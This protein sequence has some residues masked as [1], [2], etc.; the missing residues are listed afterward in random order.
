MS[1]WALSEA[2]GLESGVEVG[3]KAE[4][5]DWGS[6]RAGQGR[7][8]ERRGSIDELA[9]RTALPDDRPEAVGDQRTF[10][11]A[12][13]QPDPRKHWAKSLSAAKK[14]TLPLIKISGIKAKK[15]N[16]INE[17]VRK[18]RKLRQV[19]SQQKPTAKTEISLGDSAGYRERSLE[20]GIDQSH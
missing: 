15:S 19:Q 4:T 9:E 7:G 8:R 20:T 14:P 6:A 17:M 13:S 11:D 10:A 18:V 3:R 16:G 1:L 12:P 5:A 2:R